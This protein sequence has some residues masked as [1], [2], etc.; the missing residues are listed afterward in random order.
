MNENVEG[1]KAIY[2]PKTLFLLLGKQDQV[3]NKFLVLRSAK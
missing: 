1:S 3:H 2:I